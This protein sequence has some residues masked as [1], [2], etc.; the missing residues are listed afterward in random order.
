MQG[1][2]T[3]NGQPV[4]LPID[5]TVDVRAGSDFRK[6]A[7]PVILAQ[8]HHELEQTRAHAQRLAE[9]LRPF[10]HIHP[11]ASDEVIAACKALKAWENQWNS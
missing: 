4:A 5:Y 1:V 11:L 7:N 10:A 8:L 3:S 6:L 2:E 9:A